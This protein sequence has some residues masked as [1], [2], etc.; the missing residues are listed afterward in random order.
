MLKVSKHLDPSL[1]PAS[2]LKADSLRLCRTT[3]VNDD[4]GEELKGAKRSLQ[5]LG[6][7]PGETLRVELR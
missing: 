6:V 2:L 1:A 3:G 5:D 7:D 4:E